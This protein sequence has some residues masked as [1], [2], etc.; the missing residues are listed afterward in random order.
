MADVTPDDVYTVL[1]EFIMRLLGMGES[2]SMDTL[3]ELDEPPPKRAS[4]AA[5]GNGRFRR[6]VRTDE[7]PWPTA[8]R[9]LAPR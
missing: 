6:F 7:R 3:V 1:E 5:K 8:G 4:E 9:S 2:E